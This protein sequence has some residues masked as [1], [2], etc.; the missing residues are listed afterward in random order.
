MSHSEEVW[1][2]FL[3]ISKTTNRWTK[4]FSDLKNQS[5]IRQAQQLDSMW[6]I[7]LKSVPPPPPL[8]TG[9]CSPKTHKLCNPIYFIM[10]PMESSPNKAPADSICKGITL[11][12]WKNLWVTGLSAELHQPPDCK[13]QGPYVSPPP[14]PISAPA[15]QLSPFP[16]YDGT[17]LFWCSPQHLTACERPTCRLYHHCQHKLDSVLQTSLPNPTHL[18]ILH[19]ASPLLKLQQTP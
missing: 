10:L 11:T 9:F 5:G 12:I 2:Y 18:I 16:N 15:K 7:C 1:A 8:L 6:E 17:P 3:H 14:T 13:C 19:I 4:I